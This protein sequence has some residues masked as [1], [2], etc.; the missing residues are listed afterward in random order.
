MK[1]ILRYL[2]GITNVG[3]FYLNESKPQLIGYADAGYLFDP[4]KA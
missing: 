3:L 4:H 2:R 1:Q